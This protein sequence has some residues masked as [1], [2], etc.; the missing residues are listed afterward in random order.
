MDEKLISIVTPVYNAQD[1]IAETIESVLAQ[2]YEN[3]EMILV[4]DCS[5]DDSGKIILDYA[6]KDSRIRY[7]KQET[8]QGVANARNTAIGKV[9][10]R[11]L[12]FL[13]S[14]D[15]WYRDKLEKQ[16]QFMKEN[17]VV[18]CY[19][20]CEI[21]DKYG[22]PTGKTRYVPPKADYEQLLKGNYIPCL[23]V[24]IDRKVVYVPKM[25]SI[26]HEDYVLWLDILKDLHVAYGI[27]EVLAKYRVNKHSVSSN[28]IKAAV[29]TWN[30]YRNIE[31]LSF[32]ESCYCFICY[33]FR[34]VRKRI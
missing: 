17:A 27:N 26:P 32:K 7:F 33:L 16:L 30:I 20:A 15:L 8:N 9:K 18:F 12:A 23:T 21:I 25:L 24:M 10:G 6:D 29:W 22:K 31:Q 14:D 11:Y 5:T 19:T 28:K 1:T 13:D 4:D 34:A 2:T 3:W